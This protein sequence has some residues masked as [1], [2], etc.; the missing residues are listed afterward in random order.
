MD[1]KLLKVL[2]EIKSV[3]QIHPVHD[4]QILTYLRLSGVHQGLLLNFN[5]KKLVDGIKSFLMAPKHVENGGVEGQ[6]M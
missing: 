4:A 6:G 5:E 3:D 2:V 1:R